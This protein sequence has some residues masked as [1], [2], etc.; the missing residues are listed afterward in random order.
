MYIMWVMRH[1]SRRLLQH[2]AAVKTC[3]RPF[4][5]PG[6]FSSDTDSLLPTAILFTAGIFLPAT[7]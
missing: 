5:L 2:G 6:N 4:T 3:T 7:A 1:H